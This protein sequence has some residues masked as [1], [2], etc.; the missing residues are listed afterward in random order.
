MDWDGSLVGAVDRNDAAAVQRALRHGADVNCT[1][2]LFQDSSPLMEACQEGNN[3][4]VRILLDAGADARWINEYQF[5]AI[6]KACATG[7]L[8]I[9]ETLL[10]HD[11]DLLEIIVHE[12]GSTP[13]FTAIELQYFDI[14]RFLL[15]HSAFVHASTKV[16]LTPLMHAYCCAPHGDLAIVRMLLA[17]DVDVDD[18]D[19][20]Q[21][22]A[23]HYA[24]MFQSD[25]AVRELI[26]EHNA[27]I[28]VVDNNGDTPFDLITECQWQ[29]AV[30]QFFESY[31]NKMTRDHGSLALHAIL[32]AAEYAFVE[33]EDFRPPLKPV[34][35]QIRLQLGKLNLQHFRS[36]LRYLHTEIMRNRDDSGKLP[37]HIACENKA[38]MEVLSMLVESDAATL[39]IAD[40]AGALPLH[41][42]CCG[43]VDDSSVRFLVERGGVGTL[44]ARNRESALPLHVLC[45]STNPSWRIVQYMVQS[46]PGAVTARTNAGQYPFVIA[47][48]ESSS[49]SL[50]VVYTLVRANP[51]L[52]IVH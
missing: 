50:S 45:G 27:N 20:A 31:C 10:N 32:G 47:A 24:A 43:V 13:L 14:V 28:L 9:V 41:E 1:C 39:H 26:V 42:C 19:E 2:G 3:E 44:A 22:T 4:I 36:L 21:R 35:L 40:H 25:E 23:L 30:D 33:N 29:R 48:C 17:A 15:D 5:S 34:L 49:A 51:D 18:R 37:I 46:F 8:S 52:V 6:E 7:N 16:G 12:N 11:K 38:P